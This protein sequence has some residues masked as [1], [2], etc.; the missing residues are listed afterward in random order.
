VSRHLKSGLTSASRG[1]AVRNYIKCQE[2]AA[3]G[4]AIVLKFMLSDSV[5]LINS[6]M[7]GTV[8]STN[9]PIF[10][11]PKQTVC[12]QLYGHYRRIVRHAPIL[13][14]IAHQIECGEARAPL[15][16]H[17][18]WW[19]CSLKNICRI[20]C[21]GKHYGGNDYAENPRGSLYRRL[22]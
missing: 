19:Q 9:P 10:L 2:V 20:N 14:G 21:N 11:T 16:Y 6:C 8:R 1:A 5:S 18:F 3:Q 7:F 22:A 15:L 12:L 13:L 4:A 17:A